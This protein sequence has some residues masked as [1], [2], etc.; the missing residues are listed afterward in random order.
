MKNYLLK[1]IYL[2]ILNI[3]SLFLIKF[4]NL[5]KFFFGNIKKI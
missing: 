5:I 2:N 3:I 1:K 4:N